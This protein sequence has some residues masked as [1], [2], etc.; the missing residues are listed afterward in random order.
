[1][2][3]V[4]GVDGGASKTHAVV[5]DDRGCVLGFGSAGCA[6][7][8]V[9]GLQPAIE[10]I[11]TAAATAIA[12]AGLAPE[13]IERGYYC[14]AGAD[15][16]E[17]YR[18]L[19]KAVTELRLAQDVSVKNDTMAALRAGLTKPW[20][21]AVICG[22]GFNA[23]G[24]GPDGRELI[25]PGLGFISGD[26]GGG[27]QLSQEIIRLVMR[28][29]DGRGAKTR[30]TGRVLA[31]LDVSSEEMLM[32]HLYNGKIK[33]R[34]LLQLVPLLFEVAQEGDGPA[35]QL[36]V[37]MGKEVAITA[38]ALLRRLCLQ[39]DEVEVVLA[40]GVF[41]GKGSLLI[42]TVGE[43]VH[44]VA[45]YASIQRLH[46]AP[47]VGAALLALEAAGVVSDDAL[48]GNLQRTLPEKLRH[49]QVDY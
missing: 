9:A 6:N 11:G 41:R 10:E 24:R 32:R 1:M 25:L 33:H 28:A 49:R 18:M 22:T 23:A 16:E 20:G 27:G 29:W 42:D 37:V 7:H 3:Y 30:L 5:V 44:K 46:L 34:Q 26:W 19:R 4:L 13:A 35:R 38:N 31:Q 47:V 45:P 43:E 36:I 14:L 39:D 21:V 17:D 8:Q 48:Y 40:G 12:S 2:T 15:L